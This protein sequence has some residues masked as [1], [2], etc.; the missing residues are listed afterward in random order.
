MQKVYYIESPLDGYFLDINSEWVRDMD[1]AL[2]LTDYEEAL[3]VA[4]V[5]EGMVMTTQ[6]HR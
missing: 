6:Q 1:D 3:D 4:A 2:F 5:V